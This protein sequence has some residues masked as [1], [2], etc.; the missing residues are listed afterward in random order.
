MDK[1]QIDRIRNW[2]RG[3]EMGS[4]SLKTE[5]GNI[6]LLKTHISSTQRILSVYSRV[7]TDREKIRLTYSIRTEEP[8]P[9]L[10]DNLIVHQI[11]EMTYEEYEH[12]KNKIF[13][14]IYLKID[15]HF[16]NKEI[17]N[18][19]FLSK[20]DLICSYC[21]GKS[22][23]NNRNYIL[24]AM[25]TDIKLL[26]HEN[27]SRKRFPNNKAIEKRTHT[28]PMYSTFYGSRVTLYAVKHSSAISFIFKGSSG[29]WFAFI[30]N[31]TA[32]A[33]FNEHAIRYFES[34]VKQYSEYGY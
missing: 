14:K 11:E 19:L 20:D 10:Y 25:Q 24:K 15:K 33:F 16:I 28:N 29:V 17:H 27:Y 26:K 8:L 9:A 4:L 31:T 1:E 12:L 23:K 5:L 7:G 30:N 13:R 3:T 32:Y 6:Y 2:S 21:M 34:I 18:L 22:L